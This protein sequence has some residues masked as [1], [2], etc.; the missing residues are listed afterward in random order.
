MIEVAVEFKGLK[1]LDEAISKLPDEF[2]DKVVRAG[3]RSGGQVF[4]D[5]MGRR[6]PKDP[7]HRVIR[8]GK[9]YPVPLWQSIG[10][11]VS[12]SK[13]RA[14]ANVGPMVRAFWGRF[15]EKGTRYQSPQPFMAPTLEGDGQIAIAAFVA[16]AQRKLSDVVRK[17]NPT[18][19]RAAA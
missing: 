19:G 13:T 14:V 16:E 7:E 6:A 12:V 17:L 18:A 1:E 10:M 3:L 9:P 5:G 8:R 11:R 2:Q 15:Q 4:V